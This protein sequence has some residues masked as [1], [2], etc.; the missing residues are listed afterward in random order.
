MSRDI[1]LEGLPF[2]DEVRLKLTER[3]PGGD[4]SVT[5]GRHY[6]LEEDVLYLVREGAQAVVMPRMAYSDD[7]KAALAEL[8][9]EKQVDGASELSPACSHHP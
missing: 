8:Y 2:G 4:I 5:R 7:V 6:A 9:E 1:P 3:F